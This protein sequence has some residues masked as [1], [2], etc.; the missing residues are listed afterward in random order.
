MK[1]TIKSAR[2][3]IPSSIKAVGRKPRKG[4]APFYLWTYRAPCWMVYP[5][6][7]LYSRDT[8]TDAPSGAKQ[9]GFFAAPA[10]PES[11]TATL[12]TRGHWSGSAMWPKGDDV[13]PVVTLKRTMATGIKAEVV[14][15]PTGWAWTVTRSKRGEDKTLTG[16]SPKLGKAIQAAWTRALGLVGEVCTFEAV[17]SRARVKRGDK[18]PTA[19]NVK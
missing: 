5:S 7:N 9:P 17:T 16:T 13:R 14:S 4:R 2:S 1:L 18:R 15:T 10:T 8:A 19:H 3:V 6:L 11:P 12:A